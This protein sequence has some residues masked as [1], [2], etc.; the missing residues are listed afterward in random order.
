[1]AE[2]D[3][4]VDRNRLQWQDAGSEGF[5]V[6]E[7]IS[8]GGGGRKV[9]TN[10]GKH[11]DPFHNPA[12]LTGSTD[13]L[14]CPYGR[15]F[16][17]CGRCSI[18]GNGKHTAAHGAIYGESPGGRPWGHTYREIKSA[19]PQALPTWEE[20]NGL[21]AQRDAII[22]E[23]R[24]E[25]ERLKDDLRQAK[26]MEACARALMASSTEEEDA[27]FERIVSE[28]DALRASHE[29]LRKALEDVEHDQM[30]HAHPN[31]MGEMD[32]PEC[33]CWMRTVDAALRRAQ[34][35]G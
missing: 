10:K 4:E 25:V 5:A 30:C 11:L 32:D 1:M 24:A 2:R 9:L 15:R 13:L 35:A 3:A 27:N 12:D 26:Y 23:L 19:D 20:L 8:A 28:R 21:A 22:A 29:R 18:C 33:S 31:R 17:H 34:G 14:E 7:A 6:S 16:C